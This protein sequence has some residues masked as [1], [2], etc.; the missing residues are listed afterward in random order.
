M[1]KAKYP[2]IVRIDVAIP[3]FLTRPPSL[4]T[5]GVELIA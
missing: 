1:I 3:E 4:G 2:R 5:Y